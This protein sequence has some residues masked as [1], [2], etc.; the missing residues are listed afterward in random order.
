MITSE[1]PAPS[2]RA[3][4]LSTLMKLLVRN[5]W[6]KQPSIEDVRKRLHVLDGLFARQPR[7]IS[8]DA[9]DADGVA[10]HWLQQYASEPDCT[11]MYI[12]GGGF[13]LH[14][15]RL[16]T[17]FTAELASRLNARVLMVDYRLSPEHPF[18]AGPEDCLNAYRWLLKQEG[19]SNERL[20]IAGDSAGANLTLVTLLQA[21]QN[22]LPLPAAAWAFSPAVDCDWSRQNLKELQHL[23]PMF[24]EQATE[25][26]E[27]YFADNDRDD[28]RISPIFGDLRGL[29]PLLLETGEK[30]IFREHPAKFA[31]KARAEKVV[32]Q[33]NVWSGMMHVFQ[34]FSFLPEAKLARNAACQFLRSHMKPAE[35]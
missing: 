18:P 4:I 26:M 6:I 34:L 1:L 9:V 17:K 3:R 10:C 16:Y 21:K 12:H 35:Q 33:D 30:E 11:L 23:D 19:V 20:A 14:L 5:I 7:G 13:S 27:P 15:P 2:L 8:I 31:H 25:F 32:V 22:N 28:Y 24:S 29:P